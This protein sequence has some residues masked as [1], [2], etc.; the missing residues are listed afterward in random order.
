MP[1]AKRQGKQKHSTLI[2]RRLKRGG[3]V[4][5]YYYYDTPIARLRGPLRACRLEPLLECCAGEHIT[6]LLRNALAY[7]PFPL[8]SL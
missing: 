3:V 6:T 7:L 8:R 5:C 4:L 2:D 1:P